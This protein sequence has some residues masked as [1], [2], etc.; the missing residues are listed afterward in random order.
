LGFT[1]FFITDA[2]RAVNL[3]PQD[4]EAALREMKAAGIQ[5][6]DTLSLATDV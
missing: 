2:T 5:L 4:G 3:H 6:I 1:T